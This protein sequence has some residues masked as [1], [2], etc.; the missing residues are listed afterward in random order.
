MDHPLMNLLSQSPQLCD[1]LYI[2]N[3][4]AVV[5]HA[6][7]Y[8]MITRGLNEAN[9]PGT[10]SFPGGKIEGET[11]TA[12]VVEETLRREIREEAGVE[13]GPELVYLKSKAFTGSDG[14]PIIDLVFL[15]RYA[16]GELHAQVAEV[17]D[18]G[19]MGLEEVIAHPK[20]PPWTI[21]DIRSADEARKA[22]N[23]S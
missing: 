5:Y 14:K 17:A 3:V 9:A 8:L 12:N 1:C 10:L 7:K 11:N 22:L 4:E 21:A 2:V 15:C 16:G 19:W 20:A 6:G 23:W 13:V 18:L